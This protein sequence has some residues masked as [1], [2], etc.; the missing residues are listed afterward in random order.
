M[1]TLLLAAAG[2]AVGG[3]FGATA[4]MIGQ[5]IGALAGGVLDRAMFGSSTNTSIGKLA[6]LDVQTSNEGA[7][8]ARLFGRVRIAGEVIW[9]S[10]FE[11]SSTTE[12]SGGKGLGGSKTTTYHYFANFAIGLCEGPIAHVGRVW[13]N[14]KLIDLTR[15]TMRVH[16]GAENQQPDSLILAHQGT[17]PAYRGLAYVVF[18]RLPLDDF[19]NTLPQL[20]FEVIRPVG[21]LERKLKAVTMIPAA[22][23]FGY[24]TTRVTRTLSRGVTATENRHAATGATDFAASLDELCAVCPNLKSVALVATWFGDDLRAGAC[25]IR[26]KVDNAAK[27]TTG[28]EW[29]VSGVGRGEARLVSSV[30]GRAAYGGTPSDASV[31]EAIKALK[32]RGLA[33][34][35]NPFVM[36]DIAAGNSLPS[37]Y[38]GASQPAYPWRGRITCHPGKGVTGSPW[39]SAAAATQV[40]AFV[41][42]AQP[43]QFGASGGLPTYTGSA[44]WGY[45]RMVLHYAKLCAL[46]GGVDTFLIGSELRGLT[47]VRGANR[48]YPFVAALTTLAADVKA[49]FGSGTAVSYAADWSEWNGDQAGDGD[50]AF[51]LDPLWA[52]P[53]VDFVGIDAYFPLSDW[54]D[55]EHADGLVYEGPCDP[56]YLKANVAGGEGFDWYYASDAA[57]AAGTRTPITDGLGKPWIWRSKDIEGWWS[58]RHYDRI[59]GAELTSPTAW[60]AGMKP[61]CFTE[62]GCPAVDRGANQPNVF[63]DRRSSEG[64][65][66]WFSAGGRDDAMQRRYL[67]TIIDHFDPESTDFSEADNPPSPVDGRR[68]VDMSRAYAWTWDARPY[69]WFPLALDVWSDGGNWQTGHW[70]NGRLGAA[71]LSEVAEALLA[72]AGAGTVDA[73][74]LTGVVDGMVIGNRSSVRDVLEPLADLLRFDLLETPTGLRLADRSRL[75]R[76]DLDLDNLVAAGDDADLER[77]RA[78]D[79]DI[80]GEIAVTFLD[81]DRDGLSAVAS[82][83]R[84]GPPG[85]EDIVLP[86]MA[87]AAVIEDLADRAL[88]DR[89]AER[90]TFA[91][92]LSPERLALEPGD[93]VHLTTGAGRQALRIRKLTDGTDRRIEAVTADLDSIRRSSAA[94]TS[95]NVVSPP[96]SASVAEPVTL[97]LD[98]PARSSS[99]EAWRPYVAATAS[100]WPARLAVY[101]LSGDSP[102]LMTTLDRPATIGTL[103]APLGA[104]RLWLFDR[105]N[106]MEVELVRG[107]LSSVG[108]LALFDGANMAAVGSMDGGWEVIQFRAADLVGDRRYRLTGLLRGLGGSERFAASGH[109]SGADFVLL[110]GSVQRLPIARDQTGRPMTLRVGDATAGLGDPELVE[111]IMTPAAVGLMPLSPVHLKARRDAASGDILIGWTRRTRLDGDDFDAREVPLGE[112]SELYEVEI[113]A[114]SAIRTLSVTTPS[115]TYAAAEQIADAGGLVTS[116][117]LSVAQVSETMGAGWPAR[118]TLNV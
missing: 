59:S 103:M 85:S 104:G 22:T 63:P 42:S 89:E 105:T 41:G 34:T 31:I 70:L 78:Q 15:V 5:A 111:L 37:P 33:V 90:E 83:R 72:D 39:G 20:S 64:A 80:A 36:M 11:E 25:S 109:S 110:D 71:A 114:S 58:N 47:S 117:D 75:S 73:G 101:R 115:A 16:S 99:E 6:D 52:S 8:I 23:E 96:I 92:R 1:A 21:R 98:L 82:A 54:R 93:I 17:A 116:F 49:M 86:V 95:S 62:F 106:A 102:S 44:D 84:D 40:A 56:R 18:E 53:A 77:R 61:I 4:A 27:A 69:P 88:R 55:G 107:T 48:S 24:A 2:S 14:G 91:F 87:S 118:S 51:H 57:R 79:E 81:S 43:S 100:P 112:T 19:G 76:A 65:L 29:R 60:T 12:K 68:M 50:F 10:N 38:G 9:A 30:E 108:D 94:D 26:P 66:P 28:L 13:A 74:A 45:R 46:A 32:A 113:R 7:P 67:E 97:V 3:V 35:F